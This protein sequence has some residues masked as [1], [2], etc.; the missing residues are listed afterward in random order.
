MDVNKTFCKTCPF[1]PK[2]DEVLAETV[3]GRIGLGKSQYCHGTDNRTLCRGAR[4]WQLTILFRLGYIEAETDEAFEA[5]SR[6][7]GVEPNQQRPQPGNY[8]RAR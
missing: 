3:K 6:K 2:G 4:N 8:G 5:A 7:A 1:A